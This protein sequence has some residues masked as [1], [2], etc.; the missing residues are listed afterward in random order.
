MW[1][2]VISFHSSVQLQLYWST[3]LKYLSSFQVVKLPASLIRKFPSLCFQYRSFSCSVKHLRLLSNTWGLVSFGY[4]SEN[5]LWLC[6]CFLSSL[7]IRMKGD[8]ALYHKD[9]S[10]S[11][12]TPSSQKDNISRKINYERWC[13]SGNDTGILKKK[14]LGVLQLGVGATTVRLVLQML[15]HWVV[16]DSWQ[17]V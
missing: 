3:F 9:Y 4:I 12:L 14:E 13:P 17:I 8:E 2:Y 15:L 7:N 11:F 6:I 1:R 5:M 10:E 16:G